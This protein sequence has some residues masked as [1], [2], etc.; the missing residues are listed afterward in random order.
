M[1]LNLFHRNREVLPVI[2]VLGFLVLMLGIAT[3][4]LFFRLDTDYNVILPIAEF[5][6]R[7]YL[8]PAHFFA[9]NPDVGLGIPVLGDPTSFVFSPWF[10]PWLLLFGVYLG[11]RVVIAIS[12]IGSGVA[13]WMLLHA[14]RIE[15]RIA[16]WGAILYGTSG[17]L[18]AIIASGHVE[19]LPAYALTPIVFL[20]FF[21][22]KPTFG[23][24]GLI[25]LLYAIIFLSVDIY[26]L[27]FVS[28][29]WFAFRLYDLVTK[30]RTFWDL[31]LEG[32]HIYGMFIVFALPKL[33]P[34]IRDVLPH[35]NRLSSINPYE[36]SI[37]AFLLPIPFIVPWQVM[38]YDRP[39]L[40][41]I[42]GFH[43]NWYEYYAFITPI[44]LI[45]LFWV[46]KILSKPLTAYLLLS[47]GIGAF[48]LSLKYPYSPFYWI[49]HVFP[50]ARSFR[51]P[52]RVVVPLLV[53]LIVLLSYCMEYLVKTY[54][55]KRLSLILG[56]C[57]V[58]IVWT[59]CMSFFTMKTAFVPNRSL[60][61]SVAQEIRRMDPGKFYV[62]NF[63]C[64]MQPYLYKQSIPILNYYYGWTPVGS[65]TF[66]NTAGTAYDFSVFTYMRPTYIIA[67]SE[68]S[69]LKFGYT[70]VVSKERIR[71]WKTEH[72]TIV[73]Y[74]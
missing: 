56:I 34:F 31:V 26:G 6:I 54:P 22:S 52:Q 29:F 49:F 43:Y 11:L 65:P 19:K 28:I 46:R 24:A 66:K 5:A 74:L 64:C 7:A 33:L 53:P 4:S 41:R 68:E 58:S 25:G 14:L 42:I 23:T 45:P 3:R 55:M 12:I 47:L 71:V 57:G 35:F 17:A 40:Q 8:D 50:F 21:R 1:R 72:P 13:M 69:F 2:A 30:K 27:W 60:E 18:A 61:E 39:T 59:M 37:H 10:M 15:K 73:P 9:W 67:Y 51:V 70:I 44:A 63:A 36:G 62:A 16:Q 20:L 38:F 32:L 48:Y